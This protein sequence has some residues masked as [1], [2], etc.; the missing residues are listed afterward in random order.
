MN[1]LPLTTLRE[2]SCTFSIAVSIFPARAV[3]WTLY[4]M[5]LSFFTNSTTVLFF[6][7]YQQ[8]CQEGHPVLPLYPFLSLQLSDSYFPAGTGHLSTSCSWY[9]ELICSIQ[10]V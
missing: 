4:N 6:V 5:S 9:R 3:T 1:R 10:L 8:G 7:L 2:S